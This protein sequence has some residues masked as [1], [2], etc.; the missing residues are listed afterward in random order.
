MNVSIEPAE[1]KIYPNTLY[2]VALTIRTSGKTPQGEYYLLT[3]VEINGNL[4][5]E[6]WTKVTVSADGDFQL[7]VP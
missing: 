6:G 5:T 2:S 7:N 1:F 4:K 3:T